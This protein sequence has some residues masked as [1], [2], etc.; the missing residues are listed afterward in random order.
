MIIYTYVHIYIYMCFMCVY[1]YI[2]TYIHTCHQASL[3]HHGAGARRPGRPARLRRLAPGVLVPE[4]GLLLLL[5]SLL[6]LLV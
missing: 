5:L 3:R 6:L 1:I 2:Y 4:V